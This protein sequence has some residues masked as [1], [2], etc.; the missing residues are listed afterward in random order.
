MENSSEQRNRRTVLRMHLRNNEWNN[1]HWT[2]GRPLSTR[3]GH[4]RKRDEV[5]AISNE[6][7]ID[8]TTTTTIITRQ[9]DG[10]SDTDE[11]QRNFLQLSYSAPAIHGGG[12]SS[13][14]LPLSTVVKPPT[15][16]FAQDAVVKV[17]AN[18]F[19][20]VYFFIFGR[21][22]A[23]CSGNTPLVRF[24]VSKPFFAAFTYIINVKL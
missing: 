18:W 13:S 5:I 17:S 2:T 6:R 22:R 1:C 11:R 24:L 16:V 4:C 12:L 23:E 20:L 14:P 19:F 15:L 3:H 8:T 21:R 7:P 9:Q 10:I